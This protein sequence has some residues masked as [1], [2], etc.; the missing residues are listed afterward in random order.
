MTSA[1]RVPVPYAISL[2][3]A[4]HDENPDWTRAETLADAGP[5]PDA[6]A[7]AREAQRLVARALA[8]LPPR[9]RY[10]L[11]RRHGFAGQEPLT[12]DEIG[13]ALGLSRERI[14]QIQ[15]Q[16]QPIL[17]ALIRHYCGDGPRPRIP[18]IGGERITR[19]ELNRRVR[20]ARWGKRPETPVCPRCGGEGRRRKNGKLDYCLPCRRAVD[21]KNY[22]SR[23]QARAAVEAQG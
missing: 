16:Y 22:R 12:L 15:D 1:L 3:Q 5:G 7:F 8:E 18:R 2:D 23:Q 14:R 10:V 19:E 6:E 11:V 9:A 4:R 21:R 20:E 13:K 17:R